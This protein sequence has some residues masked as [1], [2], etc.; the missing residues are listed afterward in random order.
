M[1]YICGCYVS[2]HDQIVFCNL[3]KL[4]DEFLGTIRSIAQTNHHEYHDDQ[5]QTFVECP[6]TTCATAREA[7]TKAAMLRENNQ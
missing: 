1:K 6:R 2:S 7:I 3:H 4:A 5:I